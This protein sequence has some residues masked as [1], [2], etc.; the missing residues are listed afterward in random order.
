MHAMRLVAF[1]AVVGVVA[2]P[3]AAQDTTHARVS[4]SANT[5][6][7]KV[8]T[9]TTASTGHRRHHRYTQ[10]ELKAMAK[11]SQDS[12]QT[13]A[14]AKVPGGTVSEVELEHEH[15]T[16]VYSFDITQAGKSGVEEVLVSAIDGHVVWKGHESARHER[17]EQRA[18]ARATKH[19]AAD[20]TKK[21]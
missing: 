16:A 4:A 8:S 21:P 11:I 1:V 6:S 18:D 20:T 13:I 15:G 17:A 14:L 7:T 12:A 3:L 2:S 9:T 19:A 5:H 10:D